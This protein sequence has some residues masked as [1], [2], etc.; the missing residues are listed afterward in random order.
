MQ[1]WRLLLPE[2]KRRHLRLWLWSVAAITFAVV[3][4][5]GIT[6]LTHSGLSIVDWRPVTGVVPPLNDAQWTES[7]DRYRQFPEFQQL[8]RG[9][10]LAEYKD[11]FFWEYLHRLAARAIGVVFLIPF[12]F[13]W[14][15]GYFPRPLAVRALALFALGAL[16]GA[17]GWL[18]VKSGLVDRPSVSHYRLA[19]HFVIATTIFGFSVWLARDLAIQSPRTAAKASVRRAIRRRLGIVGALLVVQIVWGAFVAG[20]KAGLLFGTFPLIAG[21]IMPPGWL[22]LDP[23]VLNFVQNPGTVQWVHRLLGTVLLVA[24][25]VVFLR[26]RRLAPDR[27]THRLNVALLTLIALQYGLGVLT[28]I[29]HVPV[30]LATAHQAMALVILAVWV[31]SAHHAWHLAVIPV[32]EGKGSARAD[33]PRSR[34]GRGEHFEGFGI[35]HEES[36]FLRED[37]PL[38]APAAHD[39]DGGFDRRSGH[40]RELL[41][42]EWHRDER[43]LVAGTANLTRK[44]QEETGEARFNATARERRETVRQLDQSMSHSE[45][46]SAHEAGVSLEQTEERGSLDRYA[47][48]VVDRDGRGG[49]RPALVDGDGAER[50]ASAENL[51]DHVP[52]GGRRLEHLHAPAGDQIKTIGRAAL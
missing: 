1:D 9:M 31:A 42:R 49:K 32:L 6:R 7:F 47:G 13:F 21:R 38:L 16:Q 45:K 17:V 15:S 27:T 50:I 48:R 11:I 52:A 22:A 35:Q 36:L 33:P 46:E 34:S 29:Y 14:R 39:A 18:M 43:A 5:G 37:D 12:V 19:V 51:Q 24:A 41:P 26:V 10:T 40:V 3:V 28:L 23:A 30:M 8:R 20:L 44:L 25:I 2:A 4:I